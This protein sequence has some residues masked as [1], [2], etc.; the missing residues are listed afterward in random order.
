MRTSFFRRFLSIPHDNSCRKVTSNYEPSQVVFLSVT[1][2]GLTK[3]QA[4]SRFRLRFL[5]ILAQVFLALI[6]DF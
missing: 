2:R 1:I 6:I 3:A 5:V 4:A